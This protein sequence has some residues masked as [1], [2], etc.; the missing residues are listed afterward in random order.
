MT[1]IQPPLNKQPEMTTSASTALEQFASSFA[2]F[3]LQ[4]TIDAGL[5]VQLPDSDS[6]TLP[7]GELRSDR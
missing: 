3:G 7:E 5:T 1:E 2:L 4:Q 6:V